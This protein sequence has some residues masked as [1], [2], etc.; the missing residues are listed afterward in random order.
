M[1]HPSAETFNGHGN[2]L[3]SRAQPDGHHHAYTAAHSVS[4]PSL[5]SPS[6]HTAALAHALIG[7]DGNADPLASANRHPYPHP[8]RL[9]PASANDHTCSSFNS[10]T[11][12][13]SHS[14]AWF[15]TPADS[16]PFSNPLASAD[17]SSTQPNATTPGRGRDSTAHGQPDAHLT[18]TTGSIALTNS[19][20][21]VADT[22]PPGDSHP[23]PAL[24]LEGHPAGRSADENR[25]D[26]W[27][28]RLVD[29]QTSLTD[30]DR[31]RTLTRSI[32]RPAVSGSPLYG[33]SR[34]R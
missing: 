33:G 12:P 27:S 2:S 21:T 24:G 34:R 11:S 4:T 9:F 5:T 30:P 22:N 15:N 32:R 1:A 26:R 17:R 3:A 28:D 18:P 25:A 31:P 10:L 29:G 14:L 23:Y 7:D 20:P 6:A 19:Q 8:Q 13:N 16:H